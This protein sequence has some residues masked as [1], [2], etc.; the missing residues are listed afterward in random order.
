L[1]AI[2]A[3]KAQLLNPDR[4]SRLIRWLDR[5]R[6]VKR[7]AG[8]ITR[9]TH[10]IGRC[11][12]SVDPTGRP[13]TRANL[14]ETRCFFFK[15]GFSLIP[16]FFLYFFSWLLTVFKVHYINIRKIFYFFNVRFETFNIMFP[17][18]KVIFSMCDLKPFCIYTL[19]SQEKS[20]VFSIWDLKPFSIYTLCSQ[21][22]SYFFNVE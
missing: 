9:S 11:N 4:L 2:I 15:C 5:F 3:L 16:I 14:D 7:P 21:E 1:Q 8:A 20:Y 6:F 19:C 18:K 22:R 13:M 12:N 10:Q 17:R